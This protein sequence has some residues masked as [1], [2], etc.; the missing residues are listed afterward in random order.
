M[1]GVDR[2]LFVV[3]LLEMVT[4][5]ST[6]WSIVLFEKLIVPHFVKKLRCMVS[7]SS[8][9]CSQQPAAHPIPEPDESSPRPPP[10]SWRYMLRP[11]FRLRLGLPGGLF[12]LRFPPPKSYLHLSSHPC[13]PRYPPSICFLIWSPGWYLVRS[14][15]HEPSHSA[16]FSSPLLPLR[17]ICPHHLV[18]EVGYRRLHHYQGFSCTWSDSEP[19]IV[20]LQ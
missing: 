19:H 10:N 3:L 7:E 16:V 12:T 8:L 11:A 18:V 1:W 20:F 15:Y 5:S 13:V 6:P 4:L 9:P 14:A 2:A 17:I